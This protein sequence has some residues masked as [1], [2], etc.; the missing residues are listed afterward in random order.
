MTPGD[1]E[2]ARREGPAILSSAAH[3]RHRH[4]PQSSKSREPFGITCIDVPVGL[5]I[6]GF[7][8][9]EW[10]GY[11]IHRAGGALE[12]GQGPHRP[13]ALETVL[14]AAKGFLWW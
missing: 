6:E 10:G 5:P 14:L 2:R 1:W 3:D 12:G 13:L 7:V 11:K 9:L 8:W 4:G